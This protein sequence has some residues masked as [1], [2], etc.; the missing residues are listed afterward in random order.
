M[1][2]D[3]TG[4]MWIATWGGGLSLTDGFSWSKIDPRDGLNSGYIKSV[5]IE[6]RKYLDWGYRWFVQVSTFTSET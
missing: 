4:K 1:A 6:K 5:S 2:Q 3:E